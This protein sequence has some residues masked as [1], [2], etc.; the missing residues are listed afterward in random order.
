MSHIGKW[1]SLN[2]NWDMLFSTKRY[3]YVLCIVQKKCVSA[4]QILGDNV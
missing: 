4:M 2:K 1:E 3:T